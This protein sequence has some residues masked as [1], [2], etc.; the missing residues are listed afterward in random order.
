[1]RKGGIV[2]V[3]NNHPPYLEINNLWRSIMEMS[4]LFLHLFHFVKCLK[5]FDEKELVLEVRIKI[6]GAN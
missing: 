1:M 2:I 5:D 4:S 6:Y 3:K